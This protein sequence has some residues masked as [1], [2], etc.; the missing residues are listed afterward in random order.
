[1]GYWLVWNCTDIGILLGMSERKWQ[2][3]KQSNHWTG[4]VFNRRGLALGDVV[5]EQVAIKKRKDGGIEMSWNL[6]WNNNMMTLCVL[7]RVNT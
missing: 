1:M 3:N 4:L 7:N 2:I 5:R 6:I